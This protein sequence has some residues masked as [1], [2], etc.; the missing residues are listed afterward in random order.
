MDDFS[1]TT[2]L[3]IATLTILNLVRNI[4]PLFFFNASVQFMDQ[5]TCVVFSVK[6]LLRNFQ[7]RKFHFFGLYNPS[8]KLEINVEITA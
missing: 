8:I 3:L 7:K 5:D 1:F 2:T 6:F 4:V